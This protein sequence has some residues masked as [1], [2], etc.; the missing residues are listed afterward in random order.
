MLWFNYILW[1]GSQVFKDPYL[2]NIW[3]NL[4]LF[5]SKDVIWYELLLNSQSTMTTILWDASNQIC[6]FFLNHEMWCVGDKTTSFLKSPT[7]LRYWIKVLEF[8]TSARHYSNEMCNIHNR[9]CLII[10]HRRVYIEI[11][12]LYFSS[13]CFGDIKPIRFKFSR[14]LLITVDAYIVLCKS[15]SM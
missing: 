9:W 1:N 5:I 15:W 14:V 2:H 7:N 13:F 6:H 10:F 11:V 4:V 3:S 8:V 12:V